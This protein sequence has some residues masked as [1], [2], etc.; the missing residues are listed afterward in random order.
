[1]K[2]SLY[3]ILVNY[4]G[5]K[6]NKQCIDSILKS[7]SSK[8]INIVVVDNAST[9]GSMEELDKIAKSVSKVHVIKLNK[10]LGFAKGNN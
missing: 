8:D 3:V 9:D 10:N 6:Y 5:K 4:N 1:M 2:K 7:K